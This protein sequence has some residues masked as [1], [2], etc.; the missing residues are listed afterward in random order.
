MDDSNTN[1]QLWRDR[2]GVRLGQGRDD[3]LGEPTPQTVAELRLEYAVDNFQG[4]RYYVNFDKNM[5]NWATRR[6][7]WRVGCLH[8]TLVVIGLW[9]LLG[10]LWL[11]ATTALT[12]D[13]TPIVSMIF[14]LA[15]F[16]VFLFREELVKWLWPVPSVPPEQWLNDQVRKHGPQ[17]AA[18]FDASAGEFNAALREL[19]RLAPEANNVD[20]EL[21]QELRRAR[22][23]M[24]YCEWVDADLQVYLNSLLA[25]GAANEAPDAAARWE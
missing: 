1:P 10:L 6:Y 7:I 8:A 15:G 24:Q 19:Q 18:L 20:R 5:K 23:R 21:C 22:N 25:I 2:Q 17:M 11:F 14:L 12:H 4:F 9:L 3:N 13:V 16:A